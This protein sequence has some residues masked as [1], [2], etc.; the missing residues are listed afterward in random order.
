[1]LIKYKVQAHQKRI[2]VYRHRRALLL[3][4]TDTNNLFPSVTPEKLTT[5]ARYQ[6]RRIKYWRKN[7]KRLSHSSKNGRKR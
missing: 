7:V 4:K 6:Q 2:N 3:A 5:A 1:M